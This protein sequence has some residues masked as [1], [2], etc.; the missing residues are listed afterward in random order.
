MM[1]VL[2]EMMMMIMTR[3]WHEV[4]NGNWLLDENGLRV[5]H[6]NMSNLLYEHRHWNFP[7]DRNLLNGISVIPVISIIN[8]VI[9]LLLFLEMMMIGSSGG[10][11]SY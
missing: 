1:V 10:D 2:G 3:T 5:R 6:R 9:E 11:G 8:L 4:Y 7:L